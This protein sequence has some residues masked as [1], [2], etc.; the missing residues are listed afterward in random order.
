[1]VSVNVHFT[2]HDPMLHAKYFFAAPTYEDS[3]SIVPTQRLLSHGEKQEEEQHQNNHDSTSKIKKTATVAVVKPF[4]VPRTKPKKNKKNKNRNNNLG[5]ASQPTATTTSHPKSSKPTTT[6]LDHPKSSKPTTAATKESTDAML[7]PIPD[8]DPNDLQSLRQALYN[9]MV[10]GC[11]CRK[12]HNDDAVDTTIFSSAILEEIHA[13]VRNCVFV[14][15]RSGQVI[16]NDDRF[17]FIMDQTMRDLQTSVCFTVHANQVMWNRKMVGVACDWPRN[18][19]NDAGRGES[20]LNDGTSLNEDCMYDM[21]DEKKEI[22]HSLQV[23]ATS[24]EVSEEENVEWNEY[25]AQLEHDNDCYT[26]PREHPVLEDINVASRTTIFD[27]ARWK[28]CRCLTDIFL[29]NT[30]LCSFC[31]NFQTPGMF[32]ESEEREAN[33]LASVDYNILELSSSSSSASK[34]PFNITPWDTERLAKEND[35]AWTF[36]TWSIYQSLFEQEQCSSSQTLAS[37]T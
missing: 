12:D 18:M 2:F 5:K 25:I 26:K 35:E 28:P 9:R 21:G 20:L 36:S 15:H 27:L 19:S 10:Q 16:Q 29:P 6:A 8:V 30:A 11:R 14:E 22:S 24:E 33:R 17:M 3:S 13:I 1:M 37:T 7:L 34:V 23:G 31:R 32:L 4:H